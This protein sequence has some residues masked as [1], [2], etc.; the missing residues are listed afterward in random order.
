VGSNPY[1]VTEFFNR[2]NLSSRTMTL[3]STQSLTEMSTR[4]FPGEVKGLPGRKADDLTA[5]C[6][7]VV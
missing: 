1:E 6:K 7:P 3:G 4:N 5:I 2:P